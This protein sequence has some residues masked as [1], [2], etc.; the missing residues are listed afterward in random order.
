MGPGGGNSGIVW[1]LWKNESICSGKGGGHCR[2]G[3]GPARCAQCAQ[4]L[5]KC[6]GRRLQHHG[7]GEGS[8]GL[9]PVLRRGP[10]GPG[11]DLYE[12]RRVGPGMGMGPAQMETPHSAARQPGDGPDPEMGRGHR[13]GGAARLR[14]SLAP[15]EHGAHGRHLRQRHGGGHPPLFGRPDLLPGIRGGT[16]PFRRFFLPAGRGAQGDPRADVRGGRREN[17]PDHRRHHA[18]RTLQHPG[19]PHRGALRSQ[20]P[21]LCGR[22]RLRFSHGGD[23]G[24]DLRT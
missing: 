19:G 12:D 11:Q 1:R 3:G 15:P 23:H 4:V 8:L 21:E 24:G 6:P 17:A 14:V 13:A 18:G 5:A 9:R 20:G 16:G 22:C 10:E 2:R 7:S